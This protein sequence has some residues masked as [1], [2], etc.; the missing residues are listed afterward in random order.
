MSHAAELQQFV[1]G[2]ETRQ[3]YALDRRSG[4]IVY[5]EEGQADELR[6]DCRAGHLICPIDGCESRA[7]TTY[8]GTSKRHHFKHLASGARAHGPESYYHQ[9]GKG[10]LGQYLRDRYP[11]A[12]V[13]IDQQALDN[14]QRPD[15]LIH[16]SGGR[17]F[18]FELQYSPLTVSEW[19][20][21]HEGYRSQGVMDVWLFGHLAPHLQRSRYYREQRFESAIELTE[22]SRALKGAG[23]PVRFFSPDELR[24]ATATIESSDR[25]LAGWNAAELRFDQLTECRIVGERFITPTDHIEDAAR[26]KRLEVEWK[27]REALAAEE[28]VR[29]Q[30]SAAKAAGEKGEEEWA[31]WHRRQR[32]ARVQAWQAAAPK[33]LKLVALPTVPEVISVELRSDWGTIWHPAHWH[34]RLFYEFIEGQIGETFEYR[35]AIRRFFQAQPYGKDQAN[36]ALGGYLFHLR[37]E[38]YVRFDSEGYWIDG[39]I[40][41]MADLGHPPTAELVRHLLRGELFIDGDTIVFATAKGRLLRKL[42]TRREDDVL[43]SLAH[44]LEQQIEEKKR[45]EQWAYENDPERRMNGHQLIVELTAGHVGLLLYDDIWTPEFRMALRSLAAQHSGEARLTATVYPRD[46]GPVREISLPERVRANRPFAVGVEDVAAESRRLTVSSAEP[47]AE[48]A[49]SA[50][51]DGNA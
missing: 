3:L 38:G 41:V 9:L 4:R 35:Q 39:P 44:L 24:I 23:V 50:T 49:R 7:F 29:L 8:G 33:F 51:G 31:G 20:R 12:S 1:G 37:R 21:R 36:V 28:H 26:L 40:L 46:G 11:E 30:R 48:R 2:R 13:V 42:R 18:A 10:L 17:R 15:V 47:R 22:V 5:M 6:P 45:L 27:A 14:G 43:P 34:A 16:M 25:L 32:A 19:R